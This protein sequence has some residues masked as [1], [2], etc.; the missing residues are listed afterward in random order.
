MDANVLA[1]LAGGELH[2]AERDQAADHLVECSECAEETR[3]IMRL[4]PQAGTRLDQA[5]EIDPSGVIG[6]TSVSRAGAFALAASLTLPLVGIAIWQWSEIH[7]LR[8]RLEEPPAMVE[9]RVVTPQPAER[10]DLAPRVAALEQQIE[11]LSQPQ[12]NPSIIDL[13]PDVLRGSA[14]RRTIRVSSDAAFFNVIL[15][16]SNEAAYPDYA[17]EIRDSSARVIWRGSGLKRSE[18]DTFAA[19]LPARLLPDGPYEIRVLGLRG[20]R[21]TLLQRYDVN[22]Q[23]N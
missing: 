18:Y 10:P 11:R 14:A 3:L 21:E 2:D 20:V 19:A 12:L 13:E 4:E 6:R 7:H 16:I 22:I 5:R 8:E 9:T 1:R 17:L 23:Y 15:S